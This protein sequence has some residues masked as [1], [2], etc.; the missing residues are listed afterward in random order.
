MV[1]QKTMWDN[2]QKVPD[3]DMCLITLLLKVIIYYEFGI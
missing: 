2:S 1:I 3:L